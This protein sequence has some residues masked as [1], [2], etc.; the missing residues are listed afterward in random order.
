MADLSP[1]AGRLDRAGNVFSLA[2]ELGEVLHEEHR[3]HQPY[4]SNRHTAAIEQFCAPVLQ[5]RDQMENSTHGFEPVAERLLEAAP[6]AKSMQDVI[7]DNWPELKS[8][9]QDE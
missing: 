7:R 6:I 9:W 8:I 3:A 5:L 1:L 4:D 2:G